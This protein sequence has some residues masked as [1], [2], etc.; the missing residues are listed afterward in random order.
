MAQPAGTAEPT[1]PFAAFARPAAMPPVV[2]GQT[3]EVRTTFAN[4]SAV[5]V[6]AVR[7]QLEGTGR[8]EAAGARRR[9]GD[10]GNNLPLSNKL[11]VT[12]PPNA[13]L[14][15]PYF[16][17]ASIQEPRYTVA[18]QAQLASSRRARRR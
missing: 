2:P 17:R 5:D 12:V 6:K 7:V 16:T 13:A 9:S 14:T 4:R 15:R 10:A 1:G 8:L 3:F 11:T 18:D